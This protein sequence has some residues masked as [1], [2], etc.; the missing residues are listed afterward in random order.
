[1]PIGAIQSRA[2]WRGR[3]RVSAGRAIP[4]Y[5]VP[6]QSS[7]PFPSRS[8]PFGSI[9]CN[10]AGLSLCLPT[11][12]TGFKTRKTNSRLHSAARPA[13]GF[14]QVAPIETASARAYSPFPCPPVRGSPDRALTTYRS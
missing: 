1:M 9:P 8:G 12:T 3:T 11:Y 10:L 6:I 14:L 5:L 2:L 4:F 13:S 7:L